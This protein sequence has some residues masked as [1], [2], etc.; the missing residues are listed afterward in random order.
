MT[1]QMLIALALVIVVATESVAPPTWTWPSIVHAQNACAVPGV[2]AVATIATGDLPIDVAID[3]ESG[4]VYVANAGTKTISVVDTRSLEAIATWSL[5][6]EPVALAF[7]ASPPRVYVAVKRPIQSELMVLLPDTG[8]V[9]RAQLLDI[10]VSDLATNPRGGTIVYAVGWDA[11]STKGGESSDGALLALNGP[12]G[13]IVASRLFGGLFFRFREVIVGPAGRLY[14]SWTARYG[15]GGLAVF[16]TTTLDGRGGLHPHD[17]NTFTELAVDQTGARLLLSTT[18]KWVQ[19]I[20]TGYPETHRYGRAD[21]DALLGQIDA[22]R[23]ARSVYDEATGILYVTRWPLDDKDASAREL[24]VADTRSPRVLGS[25]TIGA[26]AHALVLDQATHRVFVSNRADGT[27]TVIQ[28]LAQPAGGEN[29]I[30][31]D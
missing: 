8:V 3:S 2:S 6:A 31:A 9:D 20:D 14:V 7:S 25:L 16:D 4:R 5:D 18:W 1:R 24:I 11:R 19:I 29:A 22:G 10:T 13:G 23:P 26:G 28:G 21:G 30:C 12:F 17:D 27:M 15:R